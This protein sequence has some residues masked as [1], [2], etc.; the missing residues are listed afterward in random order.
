MMNQMAIDIAQLA[1]AFTEQYKGKKQCTE[2]RYEIAYYAS[3]LLKCSCAGI[4]KGGTLEVWKMAEFYCDPLLLDLPI[5][6]EDNTGTENS[7]IFSSRAIIQVS[8]IVYY[9]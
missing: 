4:H 1:C 2:W 9:G 6:K 5:V 8:C 7:R 3:V